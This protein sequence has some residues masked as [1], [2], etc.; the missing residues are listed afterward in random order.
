MATTAKIARIER[1]KE[2]VARHAQRR[3]EPR[4]TPVSGDR[5]SGGDRHSLLLL[6]PLH[7]PGRAAEL[8]ERGGGPPGWRPAEGVV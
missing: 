1:R 6:H 8:R 5:R 4:G 7:V 3:R 2:V